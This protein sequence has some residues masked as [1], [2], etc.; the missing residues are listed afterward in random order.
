MAAPSA[1]AS[2]SCALL[3]PSYKN[4]VGQ[5]GRDRNRWT[6]PRRATPGDTRRDARPAV[7]EVDPTQAVGGVG[8][9]ERDVSKVL[10]PARIRALLV[11]S[12]AGIAVAL[13]I[14]GLY[15]LL[16]YIVNQR[17]HEIGIRLALGATRRAVFGGLFN[18]GARLVAGGLVLGLGAGIWLRRLLSTLVFGI[19]AGNPPTYGVA[20]AAF[21]SIA[22][23][24]VSLPALRAAR[25]EPIA[26]L[27]D[28]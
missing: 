4:A 24:V 19:T 28:E 9:L 25:V 11:T 5:S 16:A 1:T 6:V 7:H 18:Q 17:T 23:A 22:L 3:P 8:T 13:A 15:G 26:A 2:R 14:V 27:R 12:V 20:S 10:A 21:L